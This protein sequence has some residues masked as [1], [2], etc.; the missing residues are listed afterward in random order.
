MI[1]RPV[2][3]VVTIVFAV[4]LLAATPLASE[5]AEDTKPAPA[6]QQ[7]T[8]QASA[9]SNSQSADKTVQTKK[10]EDGE[11]RPTE[12]ISEDYAVAFPVDI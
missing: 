1:N 6:S 10:K 12:E 4:T 2:N 5:E 7:E 3:R 9:E 8:N 11:F